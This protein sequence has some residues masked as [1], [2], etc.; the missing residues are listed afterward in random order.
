MK[1][2]RIVLSLIVVGSLA[3]AVAGCAA[4]KATPQA[5]PTPP[6]EQEQ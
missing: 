4:G 2:F 6:A 5:A 3:L 1:A